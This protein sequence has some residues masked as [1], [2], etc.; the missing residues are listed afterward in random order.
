MFK[1]VGCKLNASLNYSF[2][3]AFKGNN[4]ERV[5][6]FFSVY[7]SPQPISP[8]N[9]YS[10]HGIGLTAG[11]G[12]GNGMLIFL[13]QH[14]NTV[15]YKTNK[16]ILGTSN[17]GPIKLLTTNKLMCISAAVLHLT[18]SRQIHSFVQN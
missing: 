13:C 16:S 3:E 1:S 17:L 2:N 11:V 10:L 5:F 6:F 4:F 9:K 14:N 18:D 15:L 8:D 7:I 12:R